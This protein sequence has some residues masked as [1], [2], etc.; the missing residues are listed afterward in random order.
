MRYQEIQKYFQLHGF[1]N[2]ILKEKMNN[3]AFIRFGVPPSPFTNRKELL[4]A[5]NGALN[6]NLDSI[7]DT[8]NALSISIENLNILLRYLNKEYASKKHATYSYFGPTNTAAQGICQSLS[9]NSDGRYDFSE[10]QPTAFGRD[11]LTRKLIQFH[12]H[13]ADQ[14]NFTKLRFAVKT[15]KE[16]GT[17]DSFL[18]RLNQGHDVYISQTEIWNQDGYLKL[19]PSKQKQFVKIDASDL[20]ARKKNIKIYYD[21]SKI[22]QQQIRHILLLKAGKKI[23]PN[24]IPSYQKFKKYKA[25]LE[26][27]GSYVVIRGAVKQYYDAYGTLLNPPRDRVLMYANFPKLSSTDSRDFYRYVEVVHGKAK[28]KDNELLRNELK[29]KFKAVIRLQ[30]KAAADNGEG[31]DVVTPHAFFRFKGKI[32]PGTKDL[33]GES[34]AELVTETPPSGFQGLFV[35][36]DHGN[37]TKAL[38]KNKAAIKTPLVITDK[39]EASAPQLASSGTPTIAEAMMGEAT[40]PAGNLSLNLYRGNQAKEEND[41]RQC[42]GQIESLFNPN[43]NPTLQNFMTNQADQTFSPQNISSEHLDKLSHHSA[44]QTSMTPQLHYRRTSQVTTKK[45]ISLPQLHKKIKSSIAQP[46]V[47]IKLLENEI[48]LSSKS[49]TG[50]KKIVSIKEQGDLFHIKAESP[51]L[52]Q[53]DI[54]VFGSA[55]LATGDDKPL[56]KSGT[57]REIFALTQFL[58]SKNPNIKP[59]LSPTMRNRFSEKNLAKFDTMVSQA[60]TVS[61]KPASLKPTP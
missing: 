54:V 19:E 38:E 24:E 55:I 18:R 11:T 40:G 17:P 36:D 34:V 15:A 37:I 60:L 9:K 45:G 43:L 16:G 3:T 8:N 61:A 58:I 20:T 51:N 31:L 12:G 56:L 33:F 44:P 28:L 5:L 7:L 23:P 10:Y 35:H 47:A 14:N 4:S 1:D 48:I 53:R 29:E 49:S 26:Q 42:M 50:T 39:G 25:E 21:E 27:L 32:I 52:S 2:L 46:D 41:A 13:Q 30:M 22:S 57:P 59:E 6:V